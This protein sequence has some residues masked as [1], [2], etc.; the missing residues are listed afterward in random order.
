MELE[1]GSFLREKIYQ[2]DSERI[3]VQ[4]LTLKL[5]SDEQKS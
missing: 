2:H 5:H 1:P 4:F 3:F